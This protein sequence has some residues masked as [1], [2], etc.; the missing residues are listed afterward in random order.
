[1]EKRPKNSKKKTKKIA[2]SSPFQGWG[3][4]A[5]EKKTKSGKKRPKIALLS[6]YLLYL[7][8]NVKF[9]GGLS[10]N[11]NFAKK[12]ER[13]SCSNKVAKIQL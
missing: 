13:K 9:Q 5:I 6:L 10:Q 7:Q 3:E 4:G 8:K 12:R 1:M 11:L 2:L